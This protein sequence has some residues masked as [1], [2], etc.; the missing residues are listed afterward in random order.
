M[1]DPVLDKIVEHH[2]KFE[3][4][5]QALYRKARA[6]QDPVLRRDIQAHA[7]CLV[8]AFQNFREEY[9]EPTQVRPRA[10]LK[11]LPRPRE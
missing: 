9:G 10:T 11:G 7:S 2:R 8:L 6:I 4:I 1:A 3:Q 5:A